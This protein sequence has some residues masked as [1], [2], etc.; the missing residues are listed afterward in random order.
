MRPSTGTSSYYT[1]DAQGS[2]EALTNNDPTPATTANYSYDPYGQT[3]T[4]TGTQ[5]AL[6]PYL[7][8]GGYNDPTSPQLKFGQREYN[9]Q[10]GTWSQQDPLDQINNVS[11]SNRYSYASD[12]PTNNTDPTGESSIFGD[13]IAGLGIVAGACT[14]TAGIL[15][16]PVVTLPGAAVAGGC[17]A[18]AGGTD[19][20]LAGIDYFL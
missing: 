10:V 4:A 9:A 14:V 6:N 7:Y 11:Q 12:D 19:G 17:A 15:A 18:I 2:V 20:I 5:N 13:I 8:A 3:L 1:L 16:L